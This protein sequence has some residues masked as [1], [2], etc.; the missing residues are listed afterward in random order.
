M[1]A[2][3]L[4]LAVCSLL[5]ASVGIISETKKETVKPKEKT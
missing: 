2:A 4:F 5:I 1:K 3:P